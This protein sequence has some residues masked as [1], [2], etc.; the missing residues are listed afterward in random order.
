M[1]REPTR[2]AGGPAAKAQGGPRRGARLLLIGMAVWALLAASGAEAAT[3]TVGSPLAAS[4]SFGFFGP[5]TAANATLGEPGANVTSPVNGTIV[6]WRLVVQSTG[7]PFALRVLRPAVGGETGVGTSSQVT[8]TST[9]TQTFATNLLVRAGDLI[10]LDL[11]TGSSRVGEA[12]PVSGSTVY[13]WSPPLADGSTAPQDATFPNSE[14]GFNADVAT[15]PPN[16]D[17]LGAVKRNTHNGTA[18]LSVTV[19]GPGT[20]TLRGKGV[21]TQ[22][23]A[24]T[25]SKAVSAAGTVKL[26]VK[27]KGKAKKKLN[28]T[29]KVRVKVTVTYTPAAGDLPGVPNSQTKKIKLI[30]KH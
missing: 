28:K 1:R 3:V 30:K 12:V 25:A 19:P 20:L 6:R 7:A 26:L 16:N 29:G 17:T 23:P 13:Q 18:T 21:K 8:P 22:R 10:G 11:V 27:A 24:A 9:G 15:P 5:V 14:L 4:F 2:K